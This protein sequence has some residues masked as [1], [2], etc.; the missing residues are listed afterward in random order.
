[1]LTTLKQC[2]V[3]LTPQERW[4][5]LGM[6]P[7]MLVVAGLESVAAAL[8]FGLIQSF[9]DP[10]QTAHIPALAALSQVLPGYMRQEIPLVVTVF[11]AVF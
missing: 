11:V 7:L 6:V 10:T 4:Q 9:N 2:L 8:V 3:L 1:M 5:W